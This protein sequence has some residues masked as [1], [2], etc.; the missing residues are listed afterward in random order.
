MSRPPS[1]RFY[2]SGACFNG[3]ECPF[4]HPTQRC[5]SFTSDGWCPYGVH[6]HYWHDQENAALA[7]PDGQPIQK[8]CRFFLNGQC[9]Y[10]DSCAYSHQLNDDDVG[11]YESRTLTLA[12][13][14]MRQGMLRQRRISGPRRAPTNSPPQPAPPVM[15]PPVARPTAR[16]EQAYIDALQPGD[17]EKMRELEV[18]RLIKRFPPSLLKQVPGNED[19]NIKAFSLLFSSTDPDW[20]GLDPFFLC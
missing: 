7:T 11:G 2:Q 18:D 6:C 16:L 12:E 8:V 20:V 17:L 5:R 9:S 19:D 14:K 3:D 15:R 10:G 4:S 1:C 13:Y